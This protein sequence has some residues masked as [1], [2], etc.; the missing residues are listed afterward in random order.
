[1]TN[2]DE[3]SSH[4]LGIRDVLIK[5]TIIYLFTPIRLAKFKKPDNAKCC[6]EYGENKKPLAECSSVTLKSN[7]WGSFSPI[8]NSTYL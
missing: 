1:M 3:I 5:T 2:K 8:S 7:L 4:P 6:K